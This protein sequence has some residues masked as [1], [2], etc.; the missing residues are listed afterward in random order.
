[1]YII[2]L[3]NPFTIIRCTIYF[4]RIDYTDFFGRTRRC[5]KTDLEFFKNRDQRIEKELE[6]P[7]PSSDK[8]KQ[9]IPITAQQFVKEGRNPEEI[10]EL[11]S[12]DMRREQLRLKWEEEERKLAERTDIHYED[13]RFDGESKKTI[14]SRFR[15]VFPSFEFSNE[16][17]VTFGHDLHK[18]TCKFQTQIIPFNTFSRIRISNQSEYLNYT[19]LIGFIKIIFLAKK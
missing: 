17:Y 3:S 16:N 1:M 11:F 6:P 14:F 5:L 10:S 9:Q 4:F 19:E 7:T 15:M 8:I 12:S 13:I 2:V 18:V